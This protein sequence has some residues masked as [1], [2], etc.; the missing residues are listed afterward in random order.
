[1]LNFDSFDLFFGRIYVRKGVSRE[2]FRKEGGS[3]KK[4]LIF[5]LSNTF[6]FIFCP[7][8]FFWITLWN[9]VFIKQCS[10]RLSKLK[11]N[12][13]EHKKDLFLVTRRTLLK[14]ITYYLFSFVLF[15]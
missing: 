2:G 3:D 11:K 8:S 4:F 13:L 12:F 1:M 14:I 6:F 10:F 7:L 15:N 9:L 5:P